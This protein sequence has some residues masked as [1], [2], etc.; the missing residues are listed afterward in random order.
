L[1]TSRLEAG[2]VRLFWLGGQV[3][4]LNGALFKMDRFRFRGRPGRDTNTA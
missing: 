1:L 2:L 4:R 3:R